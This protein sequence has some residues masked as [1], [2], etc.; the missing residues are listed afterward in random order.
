M[1][2]VSTTYGVGNVG[3]SAFVGNLGGTNVSLGHG[4]LS[5][6]T[7]SSPTTF[8]A[9][10]RGTGRTL[11]WIVT[12]PRDFPRTYFSFWLQRFN[13]TLGR[14]R[15]KLFYAEFRE[16]TVWKGASTHVAKRFC[17]SGRRGWQGGRDLHG[18]TQR[19]RDTGCEKT[20][21]P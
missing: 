21:Y 8:A 13:F 6:V 11:G 10:A 14:I 16:H 1:A 4:V 3:C 5:R 2:E 9:L 19:Y 20:F 17:T 15:S 7:V 18:T 12:A